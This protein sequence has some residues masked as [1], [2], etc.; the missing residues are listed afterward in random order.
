MSGSKNDSSIVIWDLSSNK[1]TAIHKIGK[2]GTNF[3]KSSLGG[4]FLFVSATS[5]FFRV[6]ET[7]NWSS[8]KINCN[9]TVET[10]CWGGRGFL[11]FSEKESSE[12]HFYFFKSDSLDS[13]KFLKT[14]SIS[15]YS[16]PQKGLFELGC[17]KQLEWSENSDRLIVSFEGNSNLLA[18]F[19]TSP[20]VSNENVFI[21]PLGFIRGP[22]QSFPLSL[23]FK[24][25]YQRGSLLAACWNT[26]KISFFPFYYETQNPINNI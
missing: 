22:P 3:L 7:K 9:K 21:F 15:S 8:K 12:M 1:Q 16:D 18:S 20:S 23:S 24:P 4:E 26:G 19:H 11:V 25:N 6:F 10:A 5:N 2:Y 13:K 14:E 17:I